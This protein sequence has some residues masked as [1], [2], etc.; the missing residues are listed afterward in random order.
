M[1]VGYARVSTAQQ[2]TFGISL[3]AQAERIRATAEAQNLTLD[4]II[5][6]AGESAR[7]LQRPGMERLM[8]L[9]VAGQ[10]KT[11]LV[12]SLSR[13]TR[14]VSD[15][16][17]LLERFRKY[18][19][20]LVSVQESLDTASA[21]GRL[22]MNILTATSQW[23][24]EIVAE[25]TRDAMFQ[26]KLNGERVG[27]IPYGFRLAADCRHIEP[28][29]AEQS[30]INKMRQMRSSGA[31]LRAIADALNRDSITTRSGSPWHHCYVSGALKAA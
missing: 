11:V 26:K 2:A 7:S 27:N 23:E 28:N 8:A 13:L 10:V 25:R 9:V 19:V 1:V 30:I 6:D 16:A 29:P 21:A 15:L 22:V 31:T 17:L 14:S 18:D 24:R 12:A 3:E 20:A 5:V 4:E